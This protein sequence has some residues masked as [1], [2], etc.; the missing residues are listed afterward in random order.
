MTFPTP[1]AQAGASVVAIQAHYYVG[2][3]FYRLWLDPTMIYS[4]ALWDGPDDTRDLAWAQSNKVDFHL[5]N[6]GAPPARRIL[7]IGCGW[8]ALLRRAIEIGCETAVGLT[9]S[10][11]QAKHIQGLDVAGLEARLENWQDHAAEA[12]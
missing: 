3:D 1:P 4:A 6:V 8:G 5:R 7:D 10:A 9:L 11:A 12:G 2:D